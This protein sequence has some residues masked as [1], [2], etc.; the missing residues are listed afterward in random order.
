MAR[1]HSRPSPS[2]PDSRFTIHHSPRKGAWPPRGRY[3]RFSINLNRGFRGF[4]GYSIGKATPTT[5]REHAKPFGVASSI[6]PQ[7]S[8]LYPLFRWSETIRAIRVIRGSILWF[9]FGL[10]HSPSSILHP[11]IVWLLVAF[12]FQFSASAAPANGRSWQRPANRHCRSF[13]LRRHRRLSR[14]RSLDAIDCKES[15]CTASGDNRTQPFPESNNSPDST[16]NS[17][18]HASTNRLDDLS[19]DNSTREDHDT[20]YSS[21]TDL[22][23]ATLRARGTIPVFLLPVHSSY[24]LREHIR[25]RA[26]PVLA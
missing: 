16:S 7:S 24:C 8:I 23:A 2:A 10:R 15:E 11:L 25:E 3:A 4:L 22:D 12:S 5:S 21:V 26:P 1:T 9:P 6:H 19:P 13:S 17:N 20:S 14:A 18:L